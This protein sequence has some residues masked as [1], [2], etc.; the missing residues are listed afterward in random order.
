MASTRSLVLLAA[1]LGLAAPARA[2]HIL[3]KVLVTTPKM[4]QSSYRPLADVMAASLIREFRRTGGMEILDRAAADAY[5]ADHGWEAVDTRDRALEAAEALGAD[6]VIFTTVTK[7]YDYLRYVMTFLEVERDLIQ[8]RLRGEFRTFS[9]PLEIG[10]LMAAEEEKMVR[11]LPLPSELADPGSLVRQVTVDPDNVP[12]GFQIAG[13][14]RADRFGPMEQVFSYFRI[15]PGENEFYTLEQQ[16]TLTRLRSREDMDPETTELL[17]QYYLNGD[18]AIRHGLQAYVVTD[19]AIPTIALMVANGIPVTT[20]LGI[21]TGYDG[22]TID[23]DCIFKTIE[24][25][26]VDSYDLA[27]RNLL[28]VFIMAP[29]PGR[30]KGIS[31][32]YLDT[33]FAHHVNSAGKHPTL[34]EIKDSMF[35]IVRSKMND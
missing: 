2:Q 19:V 4:D 10:R 6:I 27:D 7:E 26:Y 18:F 21:L 33:V 32:E 14:P 24:D 13:I 31:R 34:V 1:L 11:Y 17:N 20:P 30:Y 25:Q 35:D 8:R 23:G 12:A 9:S 28:A 3:V 29:R 22:L 15:F 16:K 5:A